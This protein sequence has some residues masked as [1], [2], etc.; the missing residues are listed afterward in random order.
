MT[1]T[2]AIVATFDTKGAECAYLRDEIV[3]MGAQALLIDIGVVD[4]AA[5][6]VDITNAEI[7]TKG[8]TELAELRQNP[9]REIASEVMIRG[10]TDTMLDLITSHKVDGMIS[11]GGTQGTNNCCRVMAALP[12][13]FPKVMLSTMASGD[14]SRAIRP[15][16]S[17]ERFM[18]CATRIGISEGR[19]RSGGTDSGTTF[20]R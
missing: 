5:I 7:A 10:A 14:T 3:R 15:R 1:K 8:G 12:Y 13:G 4:D 2:I 6:D 17:A 20:R 9:S 11:L 19:S 16:V 18:K